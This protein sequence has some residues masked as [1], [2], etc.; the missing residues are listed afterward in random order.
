MDLIIAFSTLV[1]PG[2]RE[3]EGLPQGFLSGTPTPTPQNPCPYEGSRGLPLIHQ[4]SAKGL[5]R[6]KGLKLPRGL[7]PRMIHIYVQ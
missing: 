4:G 1:S 3:W 2:T 6:G 7:P 5:Q